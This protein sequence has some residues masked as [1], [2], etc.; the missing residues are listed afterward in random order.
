MDALNYQNPSPAASEDSDVAQLLPVVPD[1]EGPPT[2][3]LAVL[4]DFAIQ[5]ALHEL[6]ILSEMLPI[7][8]PVDR[9]KAIVQF[10]HATRLMF[11]KMLAIVKWLRTSKKFEPLSSICYFLDQQAQQFVDTADKLFE[12]ARVELQQARLPLFQISTAIDVLTTGTYP[13]LPLIIK[14]AFVAEDKLTTYETR[15]TILLLNERLV[16]FL[17]KSASSLPSRVSMFRIHNGTIVMRVKGEFQI[18]ITVLPREKPEFLLL[19]VAIL[20]KDPDIGAGMDLVHPLQL[21]TIHELVQSRISLSNEPFLEAYRILHS[22]AV[23]L[24]LDVLECQARQL[25]R[26]I[27]PNYIRVDKYD[28]YKGY[29]DVQYWIN[30][31]TADR[32]GL[33]P[34]LS[35]LLSNTVTYKMHIFFDKDDLNSGLFIRHTP[36]SAGRLLDHVPAKRHIS[37]GQLLSEVIE[38]R[39]RERLLLVRQVLSGVPPSSQVHFAGD[40]AP[41][42]IYEIIVHE[43]ESPINEHLHISINAFYGHVVCQIH[44]IGQH[45][46]LRALE[47]EFNGACSVIEV[48]KI[49]NRLRIAIMMARYRTALAVSQTKIINENNGCAVLK[50]YTFPKDRI[51]I[52]YQRETWHYLVIGFEASAEAGIDVSFHLVTDY[53]GNH[54]NCVKINPMSILKKSVIPKFCDMFEYTPENLR[55][56]EEDANSS[57]DDTIDR[58][59]NSDEMLDDQYEGDGSMDMARKNSKWT[60]SDSQVKLVL[61]AL[62]DRILFTNLAYCLEKQNIQYTAVE[63]D[64]I[65]GG[66]YIRINDITSVCPEDNAKQRVTAFAEDIASAVIRLDNRRAAVFLLEITM[67]EAPLAPNFYQ[68]R[69]MGRNLIVPENSYAGALVENENVRLAVDRTTR[70]FI[71][72]FTMT[73]HG[74]VANTFMERVKDLFA[75]WSHLYEVVKRFSSVYRFFEKQVDVVSYDFYKLSLAYGP[76]RAYILHLDWDK[77]THKFVV[78][79]SHFLH[80]PMK[81]NGKPREYTKRTNPHSLLATHLT[82][83][84]N[85]KRDL[86]DLVHFCVN[87]IIPLRCITEAARG[88]VRS[89][90]T[91]CSLAASDPGMLNVGVVTDVFPYA[92][93]TVRVMAGRVTLEFVFLNSGAVLLADVTPGAP[94]APGL[95]GLVDAY[96]DYP[97]PNPAN[98]DEL[99]H[100]EVVNSAEE[101]SNP[102]IVHEPPLEDLQPPGSLPPADLESEL[103][104]LMIDLPNPRSIPDEI[105]TDRTPAKKKNDP[106]TAPP[107]RRI[108]PRRALELSRTPIRIS[109]R[110]LVRL[111]MNLDGK[112]IPFENYLDALA[113][114]PR[115]A[116]VVERYANTDTMGHVPLKTV[117]NAPDHFT[118]TAST[119]KVNNETGLV[120]LK[121][122]LSPDT[123]SLKNAIIY[124]NVEQPPDVVLNLMKKFFSKCV[125]PLYSERAVIGFL[126]LCRVTLPLPRESILHLMQTQLNIVHDAPYQVAFQL[127]P[128]AP[129]PGV[130]A[131][132][133]GVLFTYETKTLI[134]NICIRPAKISTKERFNERRY[135]EVTYHFV[136]K[137]VVIKRLFAKEEEPA[138]RKIIDEQLERSR[139]LNECPLWPCIRAVRDNFGNLQAEPVDTSNP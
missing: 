113:F 70:S 71:H 61:A 115:V 128:V 64:P 9:K 34:R 65:V 32:P 25:G 10:A 108:D 15:Q 46:D 102:Q 106:K 100:Y 31:R 76:Q 90:K 112:G 22:F 62:D 95:A 35:K 114:L 111:C 24:Q 75:M 3:S 120:T 139:S 117:N 29:L 41:A 82:E 88:R 12:L 67:K 81:Q 103:E 68:N 27:A 137:T 126:N 121:C 19:S 118:I 17:V 2:V 69:A 107:K 7:K 13:R 73:P 101:A 124:E 59:L 84:M 49:I 105:L 60:G 132:D 40:A 96:E 48:T 98:L 131:K 39:I 53:K 136:N 89:L 94:A 79:F 110:R 138:I 28:P 92:Y 14:D 99:A 134:F 119:M 6:T 57:S 1:R 125:A 43:Q 23:S 38:V 45:E 26:T 20:V 58:V 104:D 4:L 97:K 83:R 78:S 86:I 87:T 5:Q 8:D 55:D 122:Y 16:Y 130:K 54:Y 18:R 129:P 135:F 91:Y 109:C 42:L 51:V 44:A 36:P 127:T 85:D 77:D 11:V 30:E 47:K 63:T 93:D 66:P 80:L 21:N 123:Y 37:M 52:H 50:H 56:S 72:E 33:N 116:D 133:L 74:H